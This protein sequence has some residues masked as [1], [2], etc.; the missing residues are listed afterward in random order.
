MDDCAARAKILRAENALRGALSCLRTSNDNDLE[1][2]ANAQTEEQHKDDDNDGVDDD[3]EQSFEHTGPV[4]AAAQS[5][6]REVKLIDA[7][8][9]AIACV[10]TSGI[11]YPPAPGE[12][13]DPR[14]GPLEEFHQLAYAVLVTSVRDNRRNETYFAKGR[15]VKEENKP[16]AGAFI[17]Q[18]IAEVYDL[19]VPRCCGAFTS[20]KR[21]VSRN[22]GSVWFFFD[23]KAVRTASSDRD[24]PRRSEPLGAPELLT[25]LIANNLDLTH[26]LVDKRMLH[27]LAGFVGDHGPRPDLA[28][29]LAATLSCHGKAIPGVQEMVVS[30]LFTK[31]VSELFRKT[32]LETAVVRGDTAFRACEWPCAKVDDPPDGFLGYEELERGCP[33]VCVRWLGSAH[34]PDDALFYDAQTLGLRTDSN[35]WV[36]LRDLTREL[37]DKIYQHALRG[38]KNEPAATDRIN[39]RRQLAAYYVEQI[40]LV[41]LCCQDRSYNAIDVFEGTFSYGCCLWVLADNTY[42]DLLRAA[43]AFLLRSLHVDRSP[44]RPRCGYPVLPKR[45][46][47]VETLVAPQTPLEHL[48]RF[49]TSSN[50]IEGLPTKF[51]LLKEF[52]RSYLA[53]R[54]TCTFQDAARNALTLQVLEVVDDLVD[55]GFYA[56]SDHLRK[57]LGP[58][59]SVLASDDHQSSEAQQSKTIILR[60]V[61]RILGMLGQCLIQAAL[62]E[63]LAI[64]DEPIVE[65]KRKRPKTPK[66]RKGSLFRSR[67]IIPIDEA[68]DRRS[69]QAERFLALLDPPARNERSE[70]GL[71]DEAI[72]LELRL[73]KSRALAEAVDLAAM[74]GKSDSELDELLLRLAG[75][76]SDDLLREVLAVTKALRCPTSQLLRIMEDCV[77]VDSDAARTIF[78]TLSSTEQIDPID[79]IPHLSGMTAELSDLAQRSE[80]WVLLS[81]SRAVAFRQRAENIL[82]TLGRLLDPSLSN[83]KLKTHQHILL[84]CGLAPS[85]M[86]A[87]EVEKPPDL[88]DDGSLRAFHEAAGIVA[89][90][91]LAQHPAAQRAVVDRLSASMLQLVKDESKLKKAPRHDG[92]LHTLQAPKDTSGDLPWKVQWRRAAKK[93]LAVRAVAA[94]VSV[95]HDDHED[96]F[97]LAQCV[98]GTFGGNSLLCEEK[99]SLFFEPLVGVVERL[100]EDGGG[101]AE[102][103]CVQALQVLVCPGPRREDV[104][105][106]NQKLL[107]MSLLDRLRSSSSIVNAVVVDTTEKRQAVLKDQLVHSS[108]IA[109]LGLGCRSHNMPVAV[110]VVA[111]VPFKQ[112]LWGLCYGNAS[113]IR[114]YVD[115]AREGHFDDGSMHA[116]RLDLYDDVFW[117]T[118]LRLCALALPADRRLAY[119]RTADS[120]NRGD[121]W[122]STLTHHEGACTINE[123]DDSIDDDRLPAQA[124]RLGRP[125]H[126]VRNSLPSVRK[127][128][129]GAVN[130]FL[131]RLL[132]AREYRGYRVSDVA[133]AAGSDTAFCFSDLLRRLIDAEEL[134]LDAHALHEVSKIAQHVAIHANGSDDDVSVRDGPCGFGSV[135]NERFAA[136]MDRYR[137]IPPQ[138]TQV[139]DTGRLKCVDYARIVGNHDSV[140]AAVIAEERSL[141]RAYRHVGDID[142]EAEFLQRLRDE[143]WE[144]Q[145]QRYRRPGDPRSFHDLRDVAL[146]HFPEFLIDDDPDHWNRLQTRLFAFAARQYQKRGTGEKSG[147][148]ALIFDMLFAHL[149]ELRAYTW[150]ARDDAM[151]KAAADLQRRKAHKEFE[152]LAAARNASSALRVVNSAPVEVCLILIVIASFIA[153]YAGGKVYER[154]YVAQLAVGVSVSII[155]SV[156]LLFRIAAH[157]AIAK[158]LVKGVDECFKDPIRYIDL[159]CIVLE[160][161]DLLSL[162]STRNSHTGSGFRGAW[163]RLVKVFRFLKFLKALKAV[164]L[165]RLLRSEAVREVLYNF[166]LFLQAAFGVVDVIQDHSSAMTRATHLASKR[167]A[168][169]DAQAALLSV[170]DESHAQSGAQVLMLVLLTK[171]SGLRTAALRLATGVVGDA[172]RTAQSWFTERLRNG[173]VLR[174]AADEF[175]AT[176]NHLER[177]HRRRRA[178]QNTSLDEELLRGCAWT[179]KFITGLLVGQHGPMQELCTRQA[180]MMAAV[181]ILQELEHLLQALADSTSDDPRLFSAQQSSVEKFLVVSVM[182]CFAASMDGACSSNQ[183]FVA[184]SGVPDLLAAFLALPMADVVGEDHLTEIGAYLGRRAAIATLDSMVEGLSLRSPQVQSLRARLPKGL[185]SRILNECAPVHR[186]VRTPRAQPPFDYFIESGDLSSPEA[187]ERLHDEKLEAVADLVVR[188]HALRVKLWHFGVSDG[189][190]SQLLGEVDVRWRGRVERVFFELPEWSGSLTTVARQRFEQNVDLTSAETRMRQLF[191][192]GEGIIREARYL[193]RIEE[194]SK[195]FQIVNKRYIPLKYRLYFLALVLNLHMMLSST[196]DGA[197]TWANSEERGNSTA[198]LCLAVPTLLGYGA[199]CAYTFIC[200]FKTTVDAHVARTLQGHTEHGF[201]ERVEDQFSA[202]LLGSASLAKTQLKSAIG[203]TTD[204]TKT[205]QDTAK[206]VLADDDDS[207]A[208]SSAKWVNDMLGEDKNMFKTSS[209]DDNNVY[210]RMSWWEPCLVYGLGIVVYGLKFGW[211]LTMVWGTLVLVGLCLPGAIRKARD[212][213]YTTFDLIA[214]AAYDAITQD[215]GVCGNLVCVAVALMGFKWQYVWIL[216]LLDILLISDDLQNVLMSVWIPKAQLVLAFYFTLVSIGILSVMTFFVAQQDS[217]GTMGATHDW[218]ETNAGGVG[219]LPAPAHVDDV[220]DD[221]YHHNFVCRTPWTCFLRDVYIGLI[222]GQL[223]TAT[224]AMEYG[225]D[226]DPSDAM[227]RKNNLARIFIQLVFFIVVTLL[228]INVFTGI[229]L[230]TFSSLR[231]TLNE[232]KE[233]MGA[234]CFVCGADRGTLEEYDIDK[235]EHE[236]SEHNKWSYLLY[237]D[238]VKRAAADVAPVTGVDAHVAACAAV[239]SEAWLPEGTSFKLEQMITDGEGGRADVDHE[240]KPLYDAIQETRSDLSSLKEEWSTKIDSITEALGTK[241]AAKRPAPLQRTQSF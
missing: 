238:H 121:A 125:I 145:D 7:L 195:V 115:V 127:A 233:M 77:V 100:L 10:K 149:C 103:A 52:V 228:L 22:D 82:R 97:R 87:L 168:F 209:S 201:D 49:A 101:S 208:N 75:S 133:A 184:A 147:A 95:I 55:F 94:G 214:I 51:Y 6:T 36:E 156:E 206:N 123:I 21:V 139:E 3:V 33:P 237:L 35:G 178:G 239:K 197:I 159:L 19:G 236:G 216:L 194:L 47:A 46:W 122:F 146:V 193:Y 53:D 102:V 48:P 187:L 143:D 202:L 13:H 56:T 61:G 71:S 65:T 86:E 81:D 157:T 104:C 92:S 172:N 144:V 107:D 76:G 153:V 85:I 222:D 83:D 89:S 196:G 207:T 26:Q 186:K 91:L 158:S 220:Y 126:L 50:D 164:R 63:F 169:R 20:L 67:K 124:L 132:T 241:E 2:F 142:G 217:T 154:S 17:E 4:D 221:E 118:A 128:A 200:K 160:L 69:L 73:R 14:F 148:R 74:C 120:R 205:L 223:F 134:D 174:V 137:N 40:K 58:L 25:T 30:T 54:D 212:D 66:K 189:P 210:E 110:D 173:E 203:F 167:A 235:E 190:F 226:L 211:S 12:Q 135:Q 37:D 171:P 96:A 41:A 155:F 28:Q 32:F 16:E 57:L 175:R 108:L 218:S 24:A 229:I 161:V 179:V 44:H 177:H 60:I 182:E 84:K 181:N 99:A 116:H 111:L 23:F 112:L 98:C 15:L 185:L 141:V 230:D 114:S 79:T 240:L 64:R 198:A 152:R 70:E 5:M 140:A 39:R 11:K 191:E 162:I 170:N 80:Q 62:T 130:A 129:Q 42:P 43:F 31:D 183:A 188:A 105:R 131:R 138:V 151:Q 1:A 213:P 27:Q 231:E 225:D 18:V 106:R 165:T 224:L 38:A 72:L 192:D 176:C 59:F 78:Q 88:K 109:L 29:I 219:P 117:G 163:L 9:R 204:V 232:R 34:Y 68:E 215:L 8:A 199:M 227:K 119:V 166:Y 45:A 234:E 136:S 113:T 150:A 180:S 90:R 93:A